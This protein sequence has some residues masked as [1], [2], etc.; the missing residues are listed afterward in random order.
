MVEDKDTILPSPETNE[1]FEKR[2]AAL[3]LDGQKRRISQAE[4]EHQIMGLHI[5]KPCA[6]THQPSVRHRRRKYT[7]NTKK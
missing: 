1:E 5:G 6:Q 3:H 4:F 2:I 7:V